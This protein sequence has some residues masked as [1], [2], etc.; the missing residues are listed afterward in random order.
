MVVALKLLEADF[1]EFKELAYNFFIFGR[2]FIT[3]RTIC[4]KWGKRMVHIGGVVNV[5][6]EGEDGE[7]LRFYSLNA[8]TFVT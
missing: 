3:W 1:G 2:Y 5:L 8:R 4:H 7:K 6:S